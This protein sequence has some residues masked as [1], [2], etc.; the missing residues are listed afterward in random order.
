MATFLPY[1]IVIALVLGCIALG[2]AVFVIDL[3]PYRSSP[4]RFS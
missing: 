4:P 2:L 1:L 3:V